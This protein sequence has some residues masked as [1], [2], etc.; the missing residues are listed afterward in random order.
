[1]GLGELF[2][3]PQQVERRWPGRADVERLSHHLGPVSGPQEVVETDRPLDIGE[4]I[5]ILGLKPGEFLPGHENPLEIADKFLKMV[6]DN[7]VQGHQI[8]VGR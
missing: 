6:L 2:L 1:M 8:L 3:D 4:G 5:G 7:P